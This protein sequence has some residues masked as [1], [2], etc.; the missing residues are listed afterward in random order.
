MKGVLRKVLAVLTASGAALGLAAL[1][2]SGPAQA[3]T[4][5]AQRSL[6][7]WVEPEGQVRVTVRATN[8]GGLGQI[9][10]TLPPGFR[11]VGSELG[12]AATFS[13]QTLTVILLGETGVTYTVVA[14]SQEG[15]YTFSGTLTDINQV[16]RM[17]GGADTIRVGPRPTPAPTRTPRPTATPTPTPEPTLTPTPQPTATPE[18]TPTPEPTATPTPEPTL[19]PTPQP[20]P[21]PVPTATPTP[22]PTLTPTP[23]PTATPTP[24]PTVTP[25]PTPPPAIPAIEDEEPSPI[26]SNVVWFVAGFGAGVAVAG[27]LV[28][29]MLMFRR[30]RRRF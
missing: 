8:F 20:T 13:G 16:E 14:P 1:V 26:M 21:T 5:D 22:E 23:E 3:Q 18:P 17:V 9:V 19:T 10:E 2:L 27:L 7:S 30:S 28:A 4:P 15:T 25:M 11:Y 12:S 24:E 6:S 29:G